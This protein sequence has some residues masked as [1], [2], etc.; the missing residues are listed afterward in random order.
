MAKTIVEIDSEADLHLIKTVGNI[1]KIDVSTK[2]KQINL[3]IKI[4]A[5]FIKSADDETFEQITN[6]V[7]SI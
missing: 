5:Q 4:S 6:L 2:E 3:A 7:K 1:N